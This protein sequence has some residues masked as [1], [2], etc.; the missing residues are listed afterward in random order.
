MIIGKTFKFE[1]AHCLEGHA[2][3]GQ[4]HGHTY[5][6][7]VEVDGQIQHDG[8]VMDLHLLSEIV[9]EVI[10]THDH[11]CLNDLYSVSTCEVMA[12]AILHNLIQK[13]KERGLFPFPRL[14]SV[15]LQEGEGGYA[16]VY[17]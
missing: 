17:R 16:K 10:A 8:M 9:Q 5:K 7:T 15:T 11:R 1:S 2:K 14:H 6:L 3:C 13:F 4:M 12:S